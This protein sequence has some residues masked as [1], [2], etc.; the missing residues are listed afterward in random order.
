MIALL[1][2]ESRALF[3][4]L[5]DEMYRLRL[6][7]ARAAIQPYGAFHRLAV[8]DY[9]DSLDPLYVLALDEMDCVAGALRL[10]PTAGVTMLNAAFAGDLPD[11]LRVESPLIWEASRL[12]LHAVGDARATE[13]AIDRTIGQLGVAL[14]AIAETAALTHM[15]GVFDRSTHRLLSH[16]GC[17]GETLASMRIDGAD[18]F[19]VLYEVGAAMN[20]PFKSLA[21][22]ATA[23]PINLAD[24]ER[25]R[26]RG[27]R[28]S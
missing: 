5:M 25:L 2:G 7:A 20:A 18:M 24:L 26:Q 4:R 11:G 22:D 12:T 13:A 14:N 19:A 9:F 21:G 17:A 8:V 28:R 27:C 6:A 10:L 1:P 3:P 23:P 16:R 15:I